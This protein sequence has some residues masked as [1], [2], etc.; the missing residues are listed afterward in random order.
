MASF[1][2]RIKK[3]RN[4]FNLAYSSKDDV[5]DLYV[6]Y[7]YN[8][9][10]SQLNR[11]GIKLSPDAV[12]ELVSRGA[13][14]YII[15]FNWMHRLIHEMH[16][17][18][19]NNFNPRE[20]RYHEVQYAESLAWLTI[21]LA[22]DIIDSPTAKGNVTTKEVTDYINAVVFKIP[23]KQPELNASESK[24][25]A[26]NAVASCLREQ[27]KS[28]D[29]IEK[30]KQPIDQLSRAWD[31]ESSCTNMEEYRQ[32]KY[33]ISVESANLS[34]FFILGA[35]DEKYA[36][37]YFPEQKTIKDTMQSM[38]IS[39]V[40]VDSFIDFKKDKQDIIKDVPTSL[41]DRV[42]FLYA[43]IKELAKNMPQLNSKQFT[44]LSALMARPFM[45]NITEKLSST[46]EYKAN[47]RC[48]AMIENARN[49]LSGNDRS[50]I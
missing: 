15:N 36:D 42:W 26:L 31:K 1:I 11:S 9:I 48:E 24:K 21:K 18:E 38:A 30:F 23:E 22:D 43:G 10:A 34:L 3:R 39:G 5:I 14:S 41:S 7:F 20:R 8:R 6:P 2:D 47:I 29:A 40:Y 44:H 19:E 12:D 45:D 46:M 16:S 27:L 37:R 35:G 4:E 17:P 50:L 32:A 25:E 33:G 13:L 28:L 49:I